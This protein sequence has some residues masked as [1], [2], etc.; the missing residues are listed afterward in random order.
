MNFSYLKILDLPKGLYEACREAELFAKTFPTASLSSA[1]RAGEFIVKMMYAS[2][3]DDQ[4]LYGKTTFDMLSELRVTGS[5]KDKKWFDA[6][7]K[8]RKSGNTA[9]HNGE[10]DIQNALE[11][12]EELY[13]EVGF[14]LKNLGVI[15]DFPAFDISE[16]PN[17]TDEPVPKTEIEIELTKD[18]IDKIHVAKKNTTNNQMPVDLRSNKVKDS[19]ANSKAA[20]LNVKS[21]IGEN[22]PEWMLQEN[23]RMGL[24][25]ITG[26]SGKTVSLAVKSG[27]PPLGKRVN[28]VME[29]LPGIDY[30]AYAPS[31][32]IDKTYV[33]QL[34]IITKEDFLSMWNS[35]GLIRAKI[36][37]ATYNK[38]KEELPPGEVISKEKY[39]DSI[40]VQSFSNSGKKTRLLNDE[41]EKKPLLSKEGLAILGKAIE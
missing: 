27:C 31:F 26:P 6:A 7:H 8:V 30:I 36:T 14:A 22:R 23:A 37:T 9:S 29:L 3:I 16:V 2:L 13:F 40:A 5:T 28:G 33:E 15:H 24:I 32:L 4:D 41:L 21:Y 38:L 19:G 12:L 20:L 10:G 18:F 11:V 39:A 34:R 1:R 35:L 25:S 17:T